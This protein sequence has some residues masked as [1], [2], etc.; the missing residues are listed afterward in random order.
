MSAAK[1]AGWNLAVV[2][3]LIVFLANT[4]E[5]EE[6]QAEGSCQQSCC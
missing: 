5:E 4:G 6:E 1:R 2:N 3:S